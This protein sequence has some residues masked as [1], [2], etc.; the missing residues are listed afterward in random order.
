MG[1]REEYRK[2]IKKISDLDD[3][4]LR[5]SGL[6]GKRGNIELAQAVADVGDE[7][8][9]RRLLE[10]TPDKASV[11]D[12]EVFFAFCGTIGMG[13]LLAEGRMDAYKVIRSQASDPR[14]RIREAVAMA[15]QR[16]GEKDMDLLIRE[17]R[18][19]SEGNLLEKRAAA[20]ALCEPALLKR[21]EH[22]KA[23]LEIL[24]KI[25]SSLTLEKDRK[26]DEFI[27][28]KKGLSYCWS[29]AVS[30]DP[31]EGKAMMERWLNSDDKDIKAIMKEN[32]KKNRLERMDPVWV[33]QCKEKFGI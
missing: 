3:Y 16:L 31:E 32:L 17:M 27:A 11:N 26:T 5:E 8:L 22:A 13:K 18:Q 20:A 7:A 15:L 9:F 21:R 10:Y 28:L 19:W 6:P 33:K 4:L 23:T 25:T 2:K 29:V 12:A 14:W 1:K 24:D 30:S